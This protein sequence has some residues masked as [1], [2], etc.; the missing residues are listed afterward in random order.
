MR[1]EIIDRFEG[2]YVVIEFDGKTETI[3]KS[4]LPKLAKVGDFLIF[5]EGQVLMDK[6]NTQ[7]RKDE[8][9][10]LMDELFED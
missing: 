2:E 7:K 1:K 9:K 10:V 5:D 3:L 6:V 4:E 8:I